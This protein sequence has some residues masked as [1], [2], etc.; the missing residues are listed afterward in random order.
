MTHRFSCRISS[1]GER[2]RQFQIFLIGDTVKTFDQRIDMI[3]NW[4]EKGGVLLIGYDMF[5]LL[6][7][8]TQPK[9]PKPQR[10]RL[11][12]MNGQSINKYAGNEKETQMNYMNCRNTA[13]AQHQQSST[14]TSSSDAQYTKQGKREESDKDKEEDLQ[15]EDG[16]DDGYTAN[17]RVRKEANDSRSF[18]PR[19]F[20]STI[21][22]IRQNLLD[23]GP[24]LVVCDEGHKIKNL[25]SDIS[26][27]L[28]SIKTRRR[29]VLTGYPLQNNLMVRLSIYFNPS[30][31]IHLY[32]RNTTWWSTL[33]DRS[34]WAR[35]RVSRWCSKSRSR[36]DSAW[37]PLQVCPPTH[38]PLV[39]QWRCRR[40]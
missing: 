32:F 38:F 35:R 30:P 8:A 14:A 25:N 4:A 3:Q 2:L 37:T 16:P 10:P 21:L 23:P 39:Q 6:I 36:T 9:K 29:I 1:S 19:L 40:Y 28:G 33:F 20:K 24:D 18:S 26:M 5:R 7:R 11:R 34:I 13:Q 22:V 27:A 15:L 12:F 31:T 17:G